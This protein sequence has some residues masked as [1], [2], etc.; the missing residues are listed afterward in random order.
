MRLAAVAEQEKALRKYVRHY[1]VFRYYGK[2]ID[3][4]SHVCWAGHY[5]DSVLRKI[6][7]HWSVPILKIF[8]GDYLRKYLLLSEV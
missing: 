1:F 8:S 2:A 5:V 6:I 3:L 4:L 7:N